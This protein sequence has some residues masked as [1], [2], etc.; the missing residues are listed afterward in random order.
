MI[1]I[2]NLDN[3]AAGLGFG[4]TDFPIFEPLVNGLNRFFVTQNVINTPLSNY[5][6]ENLTQGGVAVLEPL[7]TVL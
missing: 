6:D 3:L 5:D 2:S 7:R 4:V 1:A